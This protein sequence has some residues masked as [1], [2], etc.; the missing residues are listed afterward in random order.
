V[1]AG[2]LGGAFDPPHNGHVALARSALERFELERLLVLVV[3][4]P[5]HKPV[6]TDVEDRLRLARLAFA[7]LPRTEV[8]RDDHAYTIDS[9]RARKVPGDALFLMGADEF[10]GFLSWREPDAV[11]EHVRVAV[12]T[13]PGY[14]R[15]PLEEVLARLERP[16]RVEFFEIPAVPVSSREVRERVHRGEPVDGLVPDAVA[17]E[18]ASAGL[19]EGV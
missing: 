1:S 17:R 13:R 4:A 19:Y 9:L 11:L 7:E 5:G 2:L 10:A 14:P 15:E 12:A 6:G 3:A 8:A 18:I 16:N